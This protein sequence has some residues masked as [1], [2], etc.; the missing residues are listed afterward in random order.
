MSMAKT[1]RSYSTLARVKKSWRANARK[2]HPRL[3]L[4][5]LAVRLLP[6]DM[7]NHR[8]TAL[9]RLAGLRLGRGTQIL[10]TLRLL[11]WDDMTRFL[12]I[13]DE[14]AMGAPCT[15]SLCAPV[16]IGHRVHTG[17]DVMI[18]SGT[19]DIAGPERRCGPYNYKPVEI[20]EG[21][22]IGARVLILPGVTIG[23]GCVVAAGAVVTRSMPPNSM[24]AG[25]PARVVG[26]LDDAD[27]PPDMD[28][29]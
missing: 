2:V 4:V 7:F 5:Q 6:Q 21:S 26:K 22:W 8:R 28:L 19:H 14:V 11:G 15:I 25:N 10:G 20:G 9:Y 3:A 16:R 12:E 27:A 23:A 29:G 24:I 13:G 18:L 17:Q 1:A